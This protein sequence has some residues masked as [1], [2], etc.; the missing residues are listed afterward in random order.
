[1]K[2]FNQDDDLVFIEEYRKPGPGIVNE[3]VSIFNMTAQERS[4]QTDK[5]VRNIKSDYERLGTINNAWLAEFDE[6]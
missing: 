3:K 5:V 1:M 6:Q 4:Y 2:F